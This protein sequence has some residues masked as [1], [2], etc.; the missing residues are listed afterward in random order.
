ME[1]AMQFNDCKLNVSKSFIVATA[2]TTTF[3]I[4]DNNSNIVY[5]QFGFLGH[6]NDSGQFQLMPGIGNEQELHLPSGLCILADK[7]G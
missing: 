1:R 7:G 6:N 3:I 2:D 5:I 4:M